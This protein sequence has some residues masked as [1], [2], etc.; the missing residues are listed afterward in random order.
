MKKLAAPL[1][2]GVMLTGMLGLGGCAP[3][4]ERTRYTMALALSP[5]TRTLTGEMTVDVFNGWDNAREEL[6]FQLWANAYREGALHAP[7]SELYAPAAYYAGESYGGIAVEE[8]QGARSFAVTGEDENILRVVLEEPLYPDERV[9]LSVCFTVTLAEV[10]HRLG[11]GENA[12][13]LAGFYPVL[14]ADGVTERLPAAVGEPLAAEHADYD[15]TLTLPQSYTAAFTGTGERTEQGG[16]AAY[17]VRAQGVRDFAMVCSETFR[18][19]EG[20]SCGV[21]VLYYSLCDEA[22]RETLAAAEE[23]LAFHAQTFGEYAYPAYTVVQADLPVSSMHFPMLS[24]LAGDLRAEELPPAAVHA[25]A[26]QWWY[27]M[28]GCDR[29]AQP[30]QDEGL[31]A[32]SCALFYDAYPAYRKTYADCVGQS[33]R[34]YRAFFSVWSQLGEAESTVMSRP[35]GGYAGEYEFLSVTR[36]KGLILFDRLQ[37]LSGQKKTLA[38]LKE[39][40]ARY[41]LTDAPPEALVAC[42]AQKSAYA[43][44]IFSSFLE[45]TCVI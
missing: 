39:Y 5:E 20:S 27:A 12:V 38:A 33:E 36:D 40:V 43:E 30:W 15:V 13:M 42:F 9:S 10:N 35:L 37:T 26:H 28:A 18:V 17:H 29:Y 23:S 31:A 7:V 32:Y 41:R 45:G 21:P 3:V 25:T 2:C 19:Y 22:P 44:G 11:I 4:R 14:C 6:S 8:V 1:L 24:M 34:A 16:T